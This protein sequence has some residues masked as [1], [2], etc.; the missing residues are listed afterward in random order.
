[1]I[2]DESKAGIDSCTEDTAQN[3]DSLSKI[4]V[5]NNFNTDMV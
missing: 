5:S 4:S 3:I 2:Q 1:M